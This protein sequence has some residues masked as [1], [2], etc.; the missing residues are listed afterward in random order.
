M[1][2]THS[3]ESAFGKGSLLSEWQYLIKQQAMRRA[4]MLTMSRLL[5]C[6]ARC[7]VRRTAI[8]PL[9]RFRGQ[10]LREARRRTRAVGAF[11]DGESVSMLAATRLRHVA[12][13]EWGTRRHLDMNRLAEASAAA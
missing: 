11:Q 12:G 13:T 5:S 1:G 2:F 4:P 6:R 8:V 7:L 3:K 9:P 10:L